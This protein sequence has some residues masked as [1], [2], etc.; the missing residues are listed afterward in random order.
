MPLESSDSHES[1]DS[2]ERPGYR[3][4][5]TSRDGVTVSK[6]ADTDRFP[7]PAIVFEI[8]SARTTRATVRL[9]D[10]LPEDVPLDDIGFHA[11]YG[12][13][14]WG[15]VGD[16]VVFERD[17]EPGEEYGTVYG[18][19]S[20]DTETLDRLLT[21]PEIEVTDAGKRVETDRTIAEGASNADHVPAAGHDAAAEHA[22]TTEGGSTGG[23]ASIDDAT[24]PAAATAGDVAAALATQLRQGNVD[25]ADIDTLRDAL[26]DRI[27]RLEG[28]HTEELDSDGFN[29]E[30]DTETATDREPGRSR[31][32]ARPAAPFERPIYRMVSD[33]P[34]VELSD[35]EIEGELRDIATLSEA[36][37]REYE[38]RGHDT[39]ARE[40]ELTR[41]LAG[42][43]PDTNSP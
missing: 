19:R 11:D 43:S 1:P 10:V 7:V 39:E 40:R 34:P 5:T 23:V 33:E 13:D 24:V 21:E 3:E 37:R 6:T 16:A 38:K 14:R 30:T 35:A 9:C 8:R 18:V 12:I 31:R 28:P 42:R 22:S 41:E 4:T 15:V 26:G 25:D 27:A 20:A 17:F 32:T 36:E 29:S 2:P